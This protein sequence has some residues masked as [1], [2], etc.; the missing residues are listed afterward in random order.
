MKKKTF[1]MAMTTIGAVIGVAVWI[2]FKTRGERDEI[3][4]DSVREKYSKRQ[5]TR[6]ADINVDKTQPDEEK[7]N[8]DEIIR[9]N[10][11]IDGGKKIDKKPYVIPPNDFGNIDEY[12]TDTLVYYADNIL[13]DDD[14]EL[15]EDVESTVGFD[16][17]AS[18]GKYGED[19]AVYVRNEQLKCDY[20]ILLDK[21]RF[22]ER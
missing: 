20:E 17:L 4:L 19:D 22:M 6:D 15:I 3:S 12:D 14:G 16:A 8:C 10:G 21:K 2:L 9:E 13:A 7:E 18:F 1:S 11:Y 5:E